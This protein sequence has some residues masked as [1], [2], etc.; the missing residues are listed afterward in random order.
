MDETG[1]DSGMEA[2][3]PNI[4][5]ADEPRDEPSRAPLPRDLAQE[6]DRDELSQMVREA[7]DGGL[8]FQQLAD[9]ARDPKSKTT[10]SKAYI[11]KLSTNAVTTAPSPERLRALA[12]ALRKPLRVV[13]RAAAAQWLDY[14][15]TELAG[16]DDEVRVI[17]AHLAGM[18]K[19]ELRRWRAMIEAAERAKAEGE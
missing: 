18:E 2:A 16:Y 17:V 3:A 7:N 9:R 14:E 13:Q 10:L 1:K 5:R 12:E 15:S 6:M 11:Q 4:N 19:S 8:S